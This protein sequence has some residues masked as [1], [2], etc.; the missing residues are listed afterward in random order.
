MEIAVALEPA[1]GHDP[2]PADRGSED[3]AARHGAPVQQDGARAAHTLVTA[4]LGVEQAESVAQGVQQRLMRRHVDLPRPAVERERD[5]HAASWTLS[6][7]AMITLPPGRGP[8]RGSGPGDPAPRRAATG[9]QRMRTR[10][11][12]ARSSRGPRGRPPPGGRPWAP[13]RQ[14]PPPPRGP[15]SDG[16]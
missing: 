12:E 13:G 3:E 5:D 6:E 4:L 1:N 9:R 16:R 8:R 7:S 10:R 11:S 14:E 15:E 2:P